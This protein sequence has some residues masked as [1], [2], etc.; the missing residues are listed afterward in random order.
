MKGRGMGE[1]AFAFLEGDAAHVAREAGQLDN[2][3]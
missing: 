3:R 1:A 2:C